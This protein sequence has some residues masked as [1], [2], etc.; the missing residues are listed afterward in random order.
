VRP[1]SPPGGGFIVNRAFP[2]KHVV[3]SNRVALAARFEREFAGDSQAY[4]GTGT[5]RWRW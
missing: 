2:A 3:R 5:P 4:S 1:R